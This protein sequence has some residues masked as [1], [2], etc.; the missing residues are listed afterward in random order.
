[1]RRRP[2]TV[3]LTF[4]A[5]FA[6]CGSR[7]GLFGET[8]TDL[9]VPDS[10]DGAAAPR[11][12][13]GVAVAD[14]GRPDTSVPPIDAG[15]TCDRAVTPIASERPCLRTVRVGTIRPTSSSCFVD[16]I[17]Q[18]DERGTL[19]FDCDGGGATM[20]FGKGTFRGSID[21]AGN[22]DLCAGTS[23]PFSDGC[24]W[25]TA[26]HITG[27]RLGSDLVFEYVEQPR[28]GPGC[29]SPCGASGFI[30]LE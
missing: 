26:Q 9:A 2:V 1:M 22:L 17:P 12:D 16:V 13:S 28:P 18:E 19:T 24:D 3:A 7:T 5:L 30:H 6:G 15:P 27:S 23:F 14:A 4:A 11:R 20:T 21:A 25:D 29:L 10:P 8:G